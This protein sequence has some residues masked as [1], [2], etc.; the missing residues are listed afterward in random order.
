MA[1]SLSDLVAVRSRWKVGGGEQ[2]V[3]SRR[4]AKAA[5]NSILGMRTALVADGGVSGGGCSKAK[6]AA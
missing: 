2:G 3:T 1:V 6:Q 4:A 5:Q